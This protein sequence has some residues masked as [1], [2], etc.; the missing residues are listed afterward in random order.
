MTELGSDHW[1]HSSRMPCR[2]SDTSM[3]SDEYAR[4]PPPGNQAV[5]KSCPG[6][7]LANMHTKAFTV[8]YLVAVTVATMGWLWLLASKLEWL[9]EG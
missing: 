9:F 7:T 8:V 5:E 6:D 3:L 1:I 2:I 4:L